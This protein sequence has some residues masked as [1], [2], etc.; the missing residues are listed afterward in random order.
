MRIKGTEFRRHISDLLI[1][2][3][4]DTPNTAHNASA[5]R[6]THDLNDWV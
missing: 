6:I 1:L 5:F 3:N 2:D 4:K